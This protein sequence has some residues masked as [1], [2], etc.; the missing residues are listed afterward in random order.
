MKWVFT[1]EN[2]FNLN[3][4]L[5]II[6]AAIGC[7]PEVGDSIEDIPK[8]D[9]DSCPTIGCMC[10]TMEALFE[11]EPRKDIRLCP[12]TFLGES[13][14]PHYDEISIP[15]L[16]KLNIC[17]SVLINFFENTDYMSWIQDS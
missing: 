15:W 4:S 17:I 8:F 2:K 11:P 9:W 16:T 6:K 5:F 10:R 14:P 3:S 7:L 12:Q 13:G 1:S